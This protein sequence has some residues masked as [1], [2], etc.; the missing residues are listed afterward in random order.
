MTLLLEEEVEIPFSFD[1]K[2]VAED[3]VKQTLAFEEF[4]YEV[5]VSMVLTDDASI[6][7]LN[8]EF[9]HMDRATDVLSFPMLSYTTAGDYSEIDE[10]ICSDSGEI[11]LGDIVISV[12]H[13][14]AQAEEFG[15]SQKRE[16]AFL[17]AHSMLHLLG[18]DHMSPEE[19][20]IMEKKQT[21][22]LEFLHITREE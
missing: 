9:R 4:P 6:H 8:Q 1:Y 7:Q 22:I 13:V 20:S 12:E 5:E 19:A 2:Q 21:K 3:V 17:I 16:F 15:H 18:Y 10:N 11:L 14:L